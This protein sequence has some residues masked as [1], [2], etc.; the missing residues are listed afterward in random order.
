MPLLIF[1]ASSMAFFMVATFTEFEQRLIA[2]AVSRK[3]LLAE[4]QE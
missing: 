1:V 4:I 3:V 2:A